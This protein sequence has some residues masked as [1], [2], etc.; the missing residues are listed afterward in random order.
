MTSTCQIPR[1]LE[2]I[3]DHALSKFFGALE[4]GLTRAAQ[5]LVVSYS[6]NFEGHQV[7]WSSLTNL[8][9]ETLACLFMNSF[10]SPSTEA[11]CPFHDF[12]PSELQDL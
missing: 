8:A 6:T 1:P 5:S 9:V 4:H 11:T 12:S 2:I 3:S 7:A 10:L